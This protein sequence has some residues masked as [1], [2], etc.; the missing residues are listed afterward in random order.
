MK[1]YY[2]PQRQNHGTERDTERDTYT[3]TYTHIH[4]YNNSHNSL[5]ILSLSLLHIILSV[6][7]SIFSH[8]YNSHINT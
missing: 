2:N 5:T 7:N 4:M 3:H 8:K 1:H 6:A